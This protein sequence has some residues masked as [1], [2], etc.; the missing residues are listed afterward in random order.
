MIGTYAL[1]LMTSLF[2]GSAFVFSKVAEE[3]VPPLVA[4][5]LRF[6]LGAIV[7][8]VMII[9]QK[10]RD[11][12]YKMVPKTAWLDTIVLGLIGVTGYNLFFFW[13]LAQSPAADGSMIIPTL[14]PA[15]TVLMAVGFL[16]ERF[17]KN[18]AVGLVVTLFGS[19]IFFSAIAFVRLPHDPHRL[20]GDVLYLL[21]A[22]LWGINT[23]LS[24]R[25]TGRIDP[26]L[27]T[28]YAMIFGSFALGILAFPQI[29][30]IHWAKVG[31][32]FWVD[33][34]Y[35]AVF[36]SVFANW[37]YYLGVKQIG[38]SRASVFMYFVPVSSLLLAAIVLGETLTIGQFIGT[39]FMMI[40]VWIIN[41]KDRT[42]LSIEIQEN[43]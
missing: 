13:G 19:I 41:R 35:L 2:W 31:L 24:K 23:L 21:A 30:T 16:K 28:T 36:P 15:I 32:P 29:M 43:A 3:S 11:P 1:L 27:V 26:F 40:G 5:F 33:Q 34:A 38:P 12:H 4:A 8:M 37:F 39:I 14:S 10:F 20:F 17:R 42:A 9:G 6:F 18:L 7:G 22:V 25:T